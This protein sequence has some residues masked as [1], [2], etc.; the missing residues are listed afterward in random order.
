MLKPLVATSLSLF[1]LTGCFTKEPPKCSD[2]DVKETLQGIYSD[3]IA[4]SQNNFM[5]MFLQALPKEIDSF[6]SIRPVAYDEKVKIRT[7]KADVT[8]ENNQTA[9]IEY[10]VQL[11]EEE[12]EEFYVELK[13][14]FLEALVQQSIMQQ[15]LNK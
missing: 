5:A 2:D 1:L 6:S 15:M 3:L 9:S 4:K 8:F 7:C 11:N 14:D 10:T 13:T 12:N